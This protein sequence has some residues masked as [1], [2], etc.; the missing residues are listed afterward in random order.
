MYRRPIR[1]K[2]A[3]LRYEHTSVCLPACL[4]CIMIAPLSWIIYVVYS[5]GGGW[6]YHPSLR[7]TLAIDV[8]R[9]LHNAAFSTTITSEARF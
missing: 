4:C 2:V 1:D 6:S 5:G 3:D 7:F 8:K 9:S